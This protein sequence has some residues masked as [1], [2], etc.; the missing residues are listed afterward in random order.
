MNGIFEVETF[1]RNEN[2]TPKPSISGMVM[3]H[4]MRSGI[5][6]MAASTP[7]APL[8]ATTTSKPSALRKRDTFARRSASSSTTRIFL[9]ILLPSCAVRQQPLHGGEQVGDLERLGDVLVRA[10]LQSARQV[11]LVRARGQEDERYRGSFR[12]GAQRGKHSE[13]VGSRH[14]DVA[15]YQV[16]V[17]FEHAPD[18]FVAV[19]GS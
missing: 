14:Q 16:R 8:A 17:I 6:A 1:S 13:A 3:S 4:T 2:S 12:S 10:S 7:E 18:A 9:V 11:F 5:C 15:D 19:R